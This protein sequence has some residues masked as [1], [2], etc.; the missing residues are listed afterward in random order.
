MKRK[1][2]LLDE[3]GISN[4]ITTTIVDFTPV[5]SNETL[6]QITLNTLRTC[7]KKYP[8]RVHGFVIMPNHLHLLLTGQGQ[9]STSQFI[10]K[11]KEYSAKSIVK[12]CLQNQELN[13]ISIFHRTATTSKRDHPYQVWQRRFD[14]VAIIKHED[15]LTK[16]NYIHNNPLQ[17]RWK[18]CQSSEDYLFSS[19]RCYLAGEEIE[20]IP[21]DRIPQ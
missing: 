13:L 1:H 11:L 16:L 6:A 12:W 8:V 14:S 4:F 17:T 2:T 5:F 10:G 7:I 15:M 9:S 3:P 19:A 18:L 20:G 21:I